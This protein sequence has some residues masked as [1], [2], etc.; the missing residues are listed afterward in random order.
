[1]NTLWTHFRRLVASLMLVAM[2]SF[3]LH[4]GAMAGMH[5]HGPGSTDCA[6]VAPAGHVH[7]A[8]AHNHSAAHAPQAGHVHGDGVAHQHLDESLDPADAGDTASDAK[9][10][11]CCASVCAIA[12]TAF[13]PDGISAPMGIAAALL[14]TSQNGTGMSLD[15]LKRPPRTPSIA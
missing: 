8:A 15:G 1:M 7:Q 11:P 13:G 12:L 3:V 5:Q 9:P 4:G 2:T 14:P 6:A 10:S